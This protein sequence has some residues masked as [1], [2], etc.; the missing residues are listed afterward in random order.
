MTDE[1]LLGGEQLKTI[2]ENQLEEGNPLCVKETLMRLVMTGTPRDE[3]IAL[4]ACALGLEMEA[5]VS[6][7]A[8]FNLEAYCKKLEELP[9]ASWLEG[10]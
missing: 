3:A 1:D 5:M 10:M 7:N 4:M 9:D 2:I 6:T 8:P